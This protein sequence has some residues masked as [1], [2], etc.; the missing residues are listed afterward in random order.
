MCKDIHS[1]ILGR[2]RHLNPLCIFLLLASF[3]APSFVPWV[4]KRAEAF[5]WDLSSDV[6]PSLHSLSSPAAIPWEEK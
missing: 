4:H 6:I 5:V 2:L 1:E 3:P